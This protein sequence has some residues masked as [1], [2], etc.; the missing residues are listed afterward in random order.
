MRAT[1]IR[2]GAAALVLSGC[3]GHNGTPGVENEIRASS[4]PRV[5]VIN[6]NWADVNVSIVAGSVPYP[7]GRVNGFQTRSFDVPG[8][9][10]NSTVRFVIREL[11]S[12]S[13]YVTQEVT[14]DAPERGLEL[15]VGSRL[16]ASELV[17]R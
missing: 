3:F 17:I 1:A 9:L 12:R 8:A 13:E 6:G 14:L 11:G 7:L 10:H 15:R 5:T 2:F 16:S 4:R